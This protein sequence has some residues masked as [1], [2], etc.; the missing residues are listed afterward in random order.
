MKIIIDEELID[1][2][3]RINMENKSPSEWD[4]IES[5]DYFQTLHYVGGWDETEQAF[6]FSYYDENRQ[7][8]WFQISLEQTNMINKCVLKEITLH[9]AK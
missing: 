2:C 7:E 3:Q 9:D 4:F 1:I 5:D 8:Y 6:C